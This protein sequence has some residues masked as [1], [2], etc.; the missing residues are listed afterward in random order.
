[1]EKLGAAANRKQEQQMAGNVRE[2]AVALLA[3]GAAP[4][5]VALATGVTP[6]Y[7]TQLLDEESVQR[8]IAE[9][10]TARLEGD[11]QHDDS[12]DGAEKEALK[13]LRQKL[14]FVRSATEAAAVF[15]ILN[16]A[17]RATDTLTPANDDGVATVSITLPRASRVFIQVDEKN[18]VVD[19]AGRSM[20][21]MP[22]KLLP[23][24]QAAAAAETVPV[25]QL[26]AS[27][28]LDHAVAAKR[29]EAAAVIDGKLMEI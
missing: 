20:A 22:S 29:L 14:P 10:R 11:V 3:A 24:M 1:M 7:I 8:A 6:A 4:S 16:N 23:K 9:K 12:I 26:T 19:V 15:K 18:Q 2:R 27:Q 21:P 5:N 17:K 13:V 25:K 28:Q